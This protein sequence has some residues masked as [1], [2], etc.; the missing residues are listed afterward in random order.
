TFKAV[1]DTWCAVINRR[2][3][4]TLATASASR[5]NA[6]NLHRLIRYKRIE[7]TN[8]SAAAPDARCHQVGQPACLL[9]D[10]LACLSPDNRLEVAYNRRERMRPDSGSQ[11]IECVLVVFHQVA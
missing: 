2:R 10:L 7:Q 1:N 6:D 5:L 9:Q 11:Q 3:V 4:L 8:R